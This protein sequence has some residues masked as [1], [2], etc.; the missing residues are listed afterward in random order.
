M[1]NEIEVC[2]TTFRRG[3]IFEACSAFSHVAACT[4]VPA[5][6]ERPLS[7]VSSIIVVKKWILYGQRSKPPAVRQNFAD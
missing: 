7:V 3:K 4:L 6:R 2:R 1:S 5:G